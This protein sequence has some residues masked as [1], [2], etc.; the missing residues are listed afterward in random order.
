MTLLLVGVLAGAASRVAYV[1]SFQPI[2][3]GSGGVGP[4]VWHGTVRIATDGLADTEYVLVGAP[5][6]VGV[7]QYPLGNVSD[8][9]VRVLG[10]GQG[11]P[12]T[13]LHWAT[14]A[15]P[16][17][18][19][20]FPLTLK[21]HESFTLLVTVTKPACDP[22][23]TWV[24]NGIPLR[25]QALGVTHTYVL[26]PGGSMSDENIPILLCFDHYSRTPHLR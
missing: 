7:I 5:G 18:P 15:E 13:A 22:N 11:T 20:S 17:T 8:K 1:Y 14:M 19:R 21:P 12:I 25:Y 23:T 26:Q 24:A 2:G 6:S 4:T 3:A 16:Y 9:Q 10:L